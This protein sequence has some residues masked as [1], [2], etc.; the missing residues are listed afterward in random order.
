MFTW[1]GGEGVVYAKLLELFLSLLTGTLVHVQVR[2]VGEFLT[3][4]TE[5]SS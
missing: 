5:P 1:S 3:N 2:N 4:V